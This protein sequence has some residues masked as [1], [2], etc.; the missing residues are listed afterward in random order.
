MLTEEDRDAL[1]SSAV[2]GDV[3]INAAFEV[4][5]HS[6]DLDYLAALFTDIAT[7]RR[8]NPQ[9]SCSAR[10]IDRYASVVVVVVVVVVE[11]VVA[12]VRAVV[13]VVVVVVAVVVGIVVAEAVPARLP[14][15]ASRI[16]Q[17]NCRD[18]LPRFTGEIHCRES[19]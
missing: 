14:A 5:V 4:A 8:N 7:V 3:V 12:V 18:V 6:Q 10:A 19:V 16:T 1:E 2:A 17:C 11:L 9:V 13:D 15:S